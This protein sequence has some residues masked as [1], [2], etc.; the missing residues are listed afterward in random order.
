MRSQNCT[1]CLLVKLKDPV[2]KENMVGPL[3]KIK[4]EQC[5]AVYVGETERS[6][7]AKF[8]EQ[9]RASSTTSEVSKHIRLDHA[10]HSVELENTEVLTT[11]PRWFERGVKRPCISEP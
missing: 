5:D 1:N 2:R 11:E 9:R 6:L 3:Y 4:C 8:S 10:Q 7:K